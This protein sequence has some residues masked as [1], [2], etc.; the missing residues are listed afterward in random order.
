VGGAL[1]GRRPGGYL[2]LGGRLILKFKIMKQDVDWIKL[3]WSGNKGWGVL[4]LV[5]IFRVP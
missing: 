2:G 3:A 1:Q 4:K 5:T